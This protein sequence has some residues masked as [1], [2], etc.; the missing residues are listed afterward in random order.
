MNI[1]D[2]IY[3]A[4]HTGLVGSA[5]VRNLESR[6]FNNLI[7]QSH[8]DLDLT[9]Q[10]LVENFFEREKP[11]YVIL[12][13]GLVGGI[14]ANNTYPADFIYQNIMIVSNVINSAYQNKVKRLLFLGSTCIYPKAVQQPMK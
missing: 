4:G 7:V 5:I 11:T 1:N 14:Q 10:R 8:T 2:K 12:A 6:G 9:N 3:I 13:A